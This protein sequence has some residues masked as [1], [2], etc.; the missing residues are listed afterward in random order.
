[1][2]PALRFLGNLLRIGL[3][4]LWLLAKWATRPQTRWVEVRL[5]PHPVEIDGS[6]PLLQRLLQRRATSRLRSIME[7]RRLLDLVAADERIAGVVVHVPPLHCGFATCESLRA[8]LGSLRTRGKRTVAYLPFGGGNRELYV[9]LAADRVLAPPQAGISLLGAASQA[10]YFKPLLDRLGLSAEVLAHGEYKTAAEPVLRE[11]MSEPQREQLAALLEVVQRELEGAVAARPGFEA[12]R[13]R[14][15][16]ETG[17]WGAAA[18]VQQGLLDGCCY[19]DELPA[20]L[21]ADGGQSAAP[22]RHRR[23]LAWRSARLWRP[24]RALPQI[25]VVRVHGAI[26]NSAPRLPASR[27]ATFETVAAALRRARQ[28]PRVHGVLLHVDSP[29]GSALASD[30]IH[31]EIV[32]VREKKPVVAYLGDVAASGGYYVAAPCNRI[33]AQATT[34]TGSIGVV[35]LRILASAFA[36]RIGLRPQTLRSAPHADLHSPFRP[37]QEDERAL[38]WAETDAIYRSFVRVVAEGR[39]RTTEEIDQVARG[40]VWAGA[41]ALRN[42]LVDELG[43]L[44]RAVAA[45]REL[46]PALRA[47]HP[48]ALE[49]RVSSAGRGEAPP[50]APALPPASWWPRWAFGAPSAIGD[51]ACLLGEGERTLYYSAIPEL[52]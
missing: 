11:A 23:Y 51:V 46:A 19:E 48:G 34:L 13:A 9:A 52:W 18:A 10:L 33:V 22:V 24:V 29:G 49:L 50:P 5:D 38:L 41:D 42:G 3:L 47:V 6:Q 39:R 17:A 14:A 1:M 43:G 27:V 4:P 25:A 15:L 32:R 7:L 26:A 12:T 30:L 28:N 21:V 8:A 37:L 35:S 44:E 2:R 16:F 40:R 36:D 20:A 31:R 45:L